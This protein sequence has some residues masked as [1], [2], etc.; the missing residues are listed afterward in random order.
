[1]ADN[2]NEVEERDDDI[3]TLVDEEGVER[4]FM[5]L[6]TVD[7]KDNWYIVLEP[8]ELFDGM[9]DGDVLIYRIG[10]NDDGDDTFINIEDEDELNGAFD[11]FMELVEQDECGCGCGCEDCDDECEHEHHHCGCGCDDCE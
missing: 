2:I 5:H 4:E 1:M 7:Y 8:T 11:A 6:A 9:E 3:I 10:L